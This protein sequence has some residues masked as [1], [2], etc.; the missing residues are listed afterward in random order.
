MNR[1]DNKTR[2]LITK[3]LVEGNSVRATARI[4]DVSK[5]TVTKL[6]VALGEVCSEYQ[7][8][9]L[10]NLPCQQIEVDEIWSFCY[11]KQKNVP[12]SMKGQFGVGDV[13]TWTAIDAETKL[14]PSWLVGDRD[15]Y[16]AGAFIKDLEDSAEDRAIVEAIIALSNSLQLSVVAEG[17]ESEGQ[18]KL[19]RESGC[20]YA[21]GF[22]F[23]Q[24]VEAHEVMALVM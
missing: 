17:V 20:Q 11:S 12:V 14:V 6:L 23:S 22:L 13:W 15:G 16:T 10:R 7:D 3:L 2:V 4:A 9:A 8:K 18:Y 19:L 1:L 24:P 21:Q 5:N